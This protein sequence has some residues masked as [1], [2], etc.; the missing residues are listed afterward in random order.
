MA[1]VETYPEAVT[2]WVPSDEWIASLICRLRGLP[3]GAPLP[4]GLVAS[5]RRHLSAE[6]KRHAIA[7]VTGREAGPMLVSRP[8]RAPNPGY[9]IYVLLAS[10]EGQFWMG[11]AA[12]MPALLAAA[13]RASGE[14]VAEAWR[15]RCR[16]DRQTREDAEEVARYI[17]AK[18][19]GPSYEEDW[20]WP[21]WVNYRAAANAVTPRRAQLWQAK[22]ADR[23]LPTRSHRDLLAEIAAVGR[24]AIAAAAPLPIW[25]TDA[26][27]PPRGLVPDPPMQEDDELAVEAKGG[28]AAAAKLTPG[29]GAGR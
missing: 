5:W 2:V 7:R 11:V 9:V 12:A 8:T 29:P 16:R 6:I 1:D 25:H 28:G 3:L 4:P 17:G 27:T 23:T 14:A 21:L 24:G 15:A 22:L 13:A 10:P 18:L 20:H 19:G 26:A